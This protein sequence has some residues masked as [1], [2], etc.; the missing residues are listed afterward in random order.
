MSTPRRPADKDALILSGGGAKGAYEIGILKALSEGR[1]SVTDFQPLEVEVLTGTSVGAFN[2]AYLASLGH[3]PAWQAVQSLEAIWRQR[4]AKTPR[5]C[6][7]E[8]FRVRSGFLRGLEPACA[9]MPFQLLRQ[10][11]ADSVFWADYVLS[12]G[13]A[14]AA[15]QEPFEV[16]ALNAVDL[17]SLFSPEPLQRLIFESI[18]PQALAQSPKHLSIAATNWQK[19]R[20]RLFDRMDVAQRIGPVA[21]AASAAIPGIFPPVDI[22]G[23][24]YVDGGVLLNTPLKPAIRAGANTLHVIY[25]DPEVADIPLRPLANTVDT[26]YRL[27][28]VMSA[29]LI[30]AD[31]RLA[32]SILRELEVHRAQKL[33]QD[34]LQVAPQA[35]PRQISPRITRRLAEGVPYRALTIHRYRPK[36]DLGGGA[37]LLNFHLEFIDQLIE[38]GYRDAVEHDCQ[39]SGC[40]L[41]QE[42][43]TGPAP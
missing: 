26:V 27:F 30:N 13:A 43:G 19:G 12:R 2:A 29:A 17:A 7:N 41:P 18:D 25:L 10:T 38:T 35:D 11:A 14:F 3:L 22:D 36:T 20:V 4:V 1:S 16:R 42:R 33:L 24:P 23:M 9:M 34:D 28:L 15:S 40:I 31:V 5:T 32:A 21:V 37:G 8:V 39:A 6:G